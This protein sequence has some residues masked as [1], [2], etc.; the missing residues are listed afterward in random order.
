VA[1]ILAGIFRAL[2][3]LKKGHLVETDR[4]GLVAGYI[5]HTAIQTREIVQQALGGVL[6]IDEAYALAGSKH[7]SDF[8]R[9]AI[10]TLLKLMEDHRDELFVIVAGYSDPMKTFINSNPGLKS[11]FTRFIQFPDYGPAELGIIF[12]RMVDQAG[13]RLRPGVLERAQALFAAYH[14]RRDAS[15]GNARL[16]RNFLQR[17]IQR[18]S[19]RLAPTA[20]KLTKSELNTIDV[21][22]L[23]AEESFQ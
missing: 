15:F 19:D 8:G 4:S 7:E 10:E 2:G 6:F 5:G 21:A 1:R 13:Y 20:T 14:G 12:Q 23:P 16:V 17:T 11:R 22:D 9:E 18:H 3:L